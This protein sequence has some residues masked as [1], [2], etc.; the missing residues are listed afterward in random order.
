[1]INHV[2]DILN[3]RLRLSGLISQQFGLTE[4]VTDANGQTSPKEYCGNGQ[5]NEVSKFDHYS[6]TSYWRKNG[7]ISM[8]ET[9]GFIACDRFIDFSIPLFLV[10]VVR[11]S[12]MND[13]QYTPDN[14]ATVITSDLVGNSATLKSAITA[15]RA[16]ISV[17][18]Y[19]TD[20]EAIMSREYSN[21]EA[22]RLRTD[23]AH[24]SLNIVVNISIKS[25][26]I[27]NDCSPSD[28]CAR[29]LASLTRAELLDCILPWY[30]FTNTEVVNSLTPQQ[31]IDLQTAL[32]SGGEPATI[33]INGTTYGVVACAGT[34]NIP[35]TNS[36]ATP[37][38]VV[39]PDVS[40]VISNITKTDTDGT[41]SS[42]PAGVNVTCTPTSSLTCAQ[43]NIGLND[44]QRQTIQRV[45]PIKTGQTTSYRVGDDGDLE[46]GRLV[47]FLT[48]DC[49]NGFGNTNRFTD[50]L[51]GQ[52]YAN[53]LVVDW[54][55]GLMW[56]RVLS[57]LVNWNTAI[58][59]CEA[60]AQAGYT[61][62]R[63]PNMSEMISIVNCGVSGGL[64]YSPF[65]ITALT[66]SAYIWTSTTS[67]GLS[68]YAVKWLYGYPLA[69][70]RGT[71]NVT[72]KTESWR[73][74]MCRNFTLPD[75]GL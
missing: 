73:H 48:L 14:I 33:Q 40:V 22:T 41:T 71:F 56:Y 47:S 64:N 17:I 37:L 6:G 11:K 18:G 59:N 74:L 57:G 58:D 26:C 16:S 54:A 39:T 10:L 42:V 69:Q 31:E 20:S 62:W 46:K 23:Y 67:P 12:V 70:Y 66:T 55:T 30:D 21:V 5:W 34:K 2:I 19:D 3:T 60:S 15:R 24:I 61:N 32:C 68:T 44:S 7:D 35:V 4:L 65:N 43:L 27:P 25:T 28:A 72:L 29:L 45:T 51:G 50:T 63:L 13:N 53:D 36:V 75:L 9:N 38:G 8:S 49:N 1:M 52:T